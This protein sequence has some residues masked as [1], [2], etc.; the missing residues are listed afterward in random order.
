MS[1]N[2]KSLSI[3]GKITIS[4]NAPVGP[5][6]PPPADGPYWG[7]YL[8]DASSS[9]LGFLNIDNNFYS[10]LFDNATS[11]VRYT[12]QDDL[13][14]VLISKT[15]D[16]YAPGNA[17]QL[18]TT[19]DDLDN[20]YIVYGLEEPGS[21]HSLIINKF[22]SNLNSTWAVKVTNVGDLPY[23]VS[24]IIYLDGFLY[25]IGAIQTGTE[26]FEVTL[27][28]VDIIDGSVDL[29]IK[30]PYT[31]NTQNLFNCK[32]NADSAG[33]LI[34]L[35]TLILGVSSYRAGVLKIS[36]SGSILLEKELDLSTSD[37][38][39]ITRVAV[40]NSDNIYAAGTD[41]TDGFILKLDSS[42]DVIWSYNI[43]DATIITDIKYLSGNLYVM[44]DYGPAPRSIF[45]MRIN[46]ADGSIIWETV[47]ESL[48]VDDM[49]SIDLFVDSDYYVLLAGVD[50]TAG[51][52][53]MSHTL[54][55]RQEIDGSGG[56]F[57]LDGNV[58]TIASG[59]NS[60]VAASITN[61]TPGATCIPVSHSTSVV[62]T[63]AITTT[64]YTA[65]IGID[66][67]VPS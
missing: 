40:D 56:T 33:N 9:R 17:Y 30:L 7:E 62:S 12:V 5:T 50:L 58:Y 29:S 67:I 55:I 46:P 37:Q 61:V 47:C 59:G 13:G 27:T 36:P 35:G 38:P 21:I 31:P 45:I 22:D 44:S 3:T 53:S 39:G 34:I 64:T 43:P 16:F 6:P 48:T 2:L 41:G 42:G 15:Y 8:R 32:I 20:I 66:S 1:V 57:E 52:A 14:N 10:F 11:Y 63:S 49:Y 26:E 18:I 51:P 4:G 19:N 24:D 25:I 65:S 23:Y 60:L 54:I 28:K